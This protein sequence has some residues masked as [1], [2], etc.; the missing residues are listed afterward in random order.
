MKS[1]EDKDFYYNAQF[2]SESPKYIA[3]KK[4]YWPFSRKSNHS[5]VE[6]ICRLQVTE[7]SFSCL[8]ADS[9][10]WRTIYIFRCQIFG[11]THQ[12]SVFS[13]NPAIHDLRNTARL[14]ARVRHVTT[15]YV[16]YL[17]CRII[18]HNS[19]SESSPTVKYS[20]HNILEAKI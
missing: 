8:Y 10:F 15:L 17:F 20:G 1:D 16:F 2:L 11:Q 5:F 14:G 3:Y 13:V 4:S 18:I 7:N 19:R 9:S 6:K 12:S